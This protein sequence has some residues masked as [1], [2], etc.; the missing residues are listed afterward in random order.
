MQNTAECRWFWKS[1]RT[2]FEFLHWF[3]GPAENGIAAG[4][5][6]KRDDCYLRDTRQTELGIKIRGGG[7]GVEVKGLVGICGEPLQEGIF[8]GEVELWTK[9]TT[10][11][12]ELKPFRVIPTAKVR[13][14]RTFE[15]VE[16]GAKEIRLDA[17]ERPTDRETSPETGCNVECTEVTLENRDVWHTL[18]FEAFGPR[19]ALPAFLRRTAAVMAAR[20]P[21]LPP[22]AIM[23]SYPRWLA[24]LHDEAAC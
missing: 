10:T 2:S 21:D 12:L 5:G 1:S 6:K 22:A 3:R 24:M 20:S 23:M 4:G 19:D 8:R 17:E 13:S 15:M 16:G 9:W 11:A 18:G 7:E 14:L